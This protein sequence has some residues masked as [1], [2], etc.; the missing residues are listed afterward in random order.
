MPT[1]H[2]DA[3]LPGSDRAEAADAPMIAVFIPALL[4]VVEIHDYEG[5]DDVH[6]HAGGQGYW[7]CKMIQA[8]GATALPCAPAGGE[9]GVALGAI[10]RSD[11]FAVDLVRTGSATRR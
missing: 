1:P 7:V 5:R 4:L 8:L 2:P 11:G 10:V 6:L 9:P 3:T